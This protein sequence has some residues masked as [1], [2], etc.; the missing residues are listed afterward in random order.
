MC[1]EFKRLTATVRTLAGF[2]LASPQGLRNGEIVRFLDGYGDAELQWLATV[3]RRTL[4]ITAR[5][6]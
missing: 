4:R 3:L 5:G 6:I 2:R 1:L